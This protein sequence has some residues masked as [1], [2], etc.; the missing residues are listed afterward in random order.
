MN[1]SAAAAEVCVRVQFHVND[2]IRK[3]N[4]K[5]TRASNALRNAELKVLRGNPSPSPA[6]SPPGVVTGNLMRTWV[7]YHSINGN[8]ALFGILSAAHYAG[9]L[10]HGTRKMDARPYVEKIKQEAISEIKAIF[11]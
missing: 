2:T 4:S 8:S 10:E 3:R 7:P 5:L 1:P 9:Y 6:G 11:L